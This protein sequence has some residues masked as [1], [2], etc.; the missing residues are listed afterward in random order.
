MM[1]IVCA[2]APAERV[3]GEIDEIAGVGVTLPPP[4]PPP[5]P[6]PPPLQ[7]FESTD[8]A[9]VKTKLRWKRGLDFIWRS[10]YRRL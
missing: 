2:L 5:E 1:V 7:P 4:P 9:R 8:A 3:A 6:E 10:I